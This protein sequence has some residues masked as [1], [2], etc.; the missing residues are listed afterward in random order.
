VQQFQNKPFVILGV[1]SDSRG[2][3]EKVLQRGD[4]QWPC[5]FDGGDAYGPIATSWH[6]R[7]WPT[8][9]LID[10]KGIIRYWNIRP[11][12]LDALLVPLLAEASRR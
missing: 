12:E 1:N 11:S 6:A 4:I 5:F 3:L 7:R 10:H 2:R 8:I 9:H